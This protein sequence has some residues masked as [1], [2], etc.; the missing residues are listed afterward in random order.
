MTGE[1]LDLEK[2]TKGWKER[3]HCALNNG[4]ARLRLSAD[5]A[6]PEK[7]YWKTWR[8]LAIYAETSQ[9]VQTATD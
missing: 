2:V 3:M 9:G 6:W 8:P 4:Y 7:R 5:T 1:D